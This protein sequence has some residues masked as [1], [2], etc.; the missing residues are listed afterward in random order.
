MSVI[1][2]AFSLIYFFSLYNHN[3]PLA[4]DLYNSEHPITLCT[5][6]IGVF[7]TSLSH[8]YNLAASTF[9]LA[10]KEMYRLARNAINFIFAGSQLKEELEEMFAFTSKEL[11][12]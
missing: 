2:N 4:P 1:V 3:F 5:D 6:D 10:K 9:G 7:S 11:E 8:E 12:I